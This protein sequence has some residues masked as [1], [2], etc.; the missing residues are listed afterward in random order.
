LRICHVIESA[1]G[2]SAAIMVSL[3]RQMVRMGHDVHVV[4]SPD[5]ADPAIVSAIA[6]AGCVST[7]QVQM[8]RAVTPA[9]AIDGFRLRNAISSL[10]PLDVIHSHS[11]KAGAL[12]R[13]FCQF[14]AT[15]QIYSPHGFYTMTG[16]APFYVGPVERVLGKLT[17]RIIAVSKFEAEHAASIG[18][19]PAKVE[20]VLNGIDPF[21]PLPRPKARAE[22]GLAEEGFVVGFVGRLSPQK[23]PVRAIEVAEAM[24]SDAAVTLCII[25]DGELAAETAKK[26]GASNA[27]IVLAG[28]RAARPLMSAFDC[29]LCTSLYEGMPVSFLEALNCG[30]PIVTY[31]VGGA[32]ELVSEPQTGVV[33]E[34]DP[35]ATA[36]AIAGL[37]A[38]S[39]SQRQWL[40]ERCQ[41]TAAV[42]SAAVM[43]EDTVAAYRRA[44]KRSAGNGGGAA[45]RNHA[46]SAG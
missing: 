39:S 29:L 21:E 42:H 6:E 4:Y 43:A 1:A 13:I 18:L 14:R 38:L 40:G 33:T 36:Q 34:P 5:R 41:A 19:D 26:A 46:S 45:D 8:R 3:A 30:V 20:V 7:L 16:E 15:A 32:E 12:A 9:D 10:G 17:D 23:A 37:M 22:L 11:S 24:P 28:G 27:K 35:A 31:P 2:G 25:G 44:L